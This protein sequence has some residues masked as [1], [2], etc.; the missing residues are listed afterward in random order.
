MVEADLV[1]FIGGEPVGEDAG[2]D[3]GDICGCG[4][5]VDEV[6]LVAYCVAVVKLWQERVGD[7][8]SILEYSDAGTF[9]RTWDSLGVG[10]LHAI[11]TWEIAFRWLSRRP[12]VVVLRWGRGGAAL[13]LRTGVAA[14]MKG[15]DGQVRDQ[16]ST[17]QTEI[18]VKQDASLN[19]RSLFP[20]Q[21]S[22][23]SFTKSGRSW[24]THHQEL[25]NGIP[26]CITV[27]FIY[28][29]ICL[30]ISGKRAMWKLSDAPPCT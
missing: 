11:S 7:Q 1:A 24:K 26:G 20:T 15:W 30:A 6:R 13:T 2:P 8:V 27:T 28:L 25:W 17:K 23:A 18:R 21:G 3:A 12:S 16:I 14:T 4:L 19:P 5:A 10:D 9:A 22:Q 29:E